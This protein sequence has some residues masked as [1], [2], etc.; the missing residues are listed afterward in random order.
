MLSPARPSL[1]PSRLPS[2]AAAAAVAGLA[3]LASADLVTNGSF[4]TGDFSGWTVTNA[5]VGSNLS[6]AAGG[7]LGPFAA[8][9][10][11]TG[12]G[13]DGIAQT[14]ATSAGT[15]YTVSFW[16]LNNGVGD[17]SLLID[18]EGATV[19]NQSP[20]EAPLESWS[21][22]SFNVSAGLNGSELRFRGFDSI[23]S[24]AID[25]ISVVAVPA[26]GAFALAGALGLARR[27]SRR[28]A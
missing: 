7:Y 3:P 15:E 10:Q 5:P 21:F 20:V 13:Y 16:I 9:F 4:Q 8:Y 2:L 24:F 17:D 18:W 1:R 23:S 28:R 22:V 6:V 14:L 19:F 26:P 27:R 11:G 12:P 25:D